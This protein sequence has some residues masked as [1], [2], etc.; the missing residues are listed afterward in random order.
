MPKHARD[1]DLPKD[2]LDAKLSSWLR[3]H[4]QETS[5][6]PSIYTL[7]VGMP[8][9]MAD[10]VDRSRQIYRGR[11]GMIWGWTLASGCIPEGIKG[12]LV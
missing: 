3:K 10:N 4:D 12:N 8:V 9:R 2:K 1:R 7:V 5:H 6:V 11:E